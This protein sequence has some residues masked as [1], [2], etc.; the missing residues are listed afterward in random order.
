MTPLHLAAIS[1]DGDMVRYLLLS[2]AD[3]NK[4]NRVETNYTNNNNNN[5]NKNYNK[6]NNNSNNNNK[7]I[8]KQ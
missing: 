3:C 7:I 6:Y 8:I 1:G 4:M 5:N 2:N